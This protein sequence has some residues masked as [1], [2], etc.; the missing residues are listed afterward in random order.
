[1]LQTRVSQIITSN[2]AQTRLDSTRLTQPFHPSVRTLVESLYTAYL[3]A[4][5]VDQHQLLCAAL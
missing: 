3:I 2:R 4:S 5:V 1:M